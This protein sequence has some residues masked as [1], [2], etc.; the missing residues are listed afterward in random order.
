MPDQVKTTVVNRRTD[1]GK[2][3]VY[4]GRGSK[5]GN[6]FYIGVDGNRTQILEKYSAYLKTRPDLLA[7]I[8]ELKGKVLGCYCKPQ[9]CHGDIL[10]QMADE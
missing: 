1:P 8:P 10:A 4:I 7:A 5:W 2:E 9:K 3:Q 6:P